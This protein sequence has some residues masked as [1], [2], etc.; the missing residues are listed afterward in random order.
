MP[1]VDILVNPEERTIKVIDNGLG[2][3]EDEVV[4]L[5]SQTP[6][7]VYMIGFLPGFPYLGGLDSGYYSKIKISLSK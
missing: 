7:R 4:R 5:H 6:Y 1:R 2:M 3:T